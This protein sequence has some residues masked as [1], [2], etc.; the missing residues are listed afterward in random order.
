[1]TSRSANPST[2]MSASKPGAI[3]RT[4]TSPPGR[5]GRSARSSA[6]SISNAPPRFPARASPFTW[7]RAPAWNAP[8]PT[9][10]STCTRASTATQKCCRRTWSTRARFS[11][12]ASFRSSPKTCSTATTRAVRSGRVQDSD[13]W[14]IP[15]AEVPVTNIFRDETMDLSNGTISLHRLHALLPLRSGLLRQG[16]S[17]H[18][19]S[20]PVPESRAGQVH[21]PGRFRRRARNADA[22]RRSRA[23]S[24]GAA[25]SPHAALH[26]RYG[27]RFVQDLRPRSLAARPGHYREISSCSNFEASRPAARTSATSPRARSKAEFV[28]TLNGS[29][30]AVGR[31]WLAILENYQQADGSVRV[32]DALLPYMGGE[33]VIRKQPLGRPA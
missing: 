21:P 13:H 29:G 23:R 4:S 14:L 33:T 8:S 11:A 16:R 32:P 9:S 26:R 1:M 2:T 22:P 3:R 12:P 28:H 27:L 31:T 19:P 6:S 20:A 18:H 17:R 25:L 15:T 10:C 5:T 30:L 7:A 24:A